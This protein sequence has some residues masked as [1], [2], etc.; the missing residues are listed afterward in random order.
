MAV[1]SSA[2][3]P[4]IK[5]LSLI[6]KNGLFTNFPS[7]DNSSTISFFVKSRISKFIDLKLLPLVLN[8][9]FLSNEN[10]TSVD[11]RGLNFNP[12]NK[13]WSESENLSVNYIICSKKY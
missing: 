9:F 2:L 5:L 3:N 1:Y 7:F 12:L 8:I 13:R 10:F 4:S 6:I 11:V